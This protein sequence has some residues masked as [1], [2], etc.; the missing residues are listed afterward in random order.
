MVLLT[1]LPR[2]GDWICRQGNGEDQEIVWSPTFARHVCHLLAVEIVSQVHVPTRHC[3][4]GVL[5]ISFLK[6]FLGPLEKFL[7][8]NLENQCRCVHHLCGLTP[9]CPTATRGM[10][11]S[12]SAQPAF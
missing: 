12:R 7:A 2:L 5:L 1:L 9:F 10:A 6:S 11:S 8:E 4:A 3:G